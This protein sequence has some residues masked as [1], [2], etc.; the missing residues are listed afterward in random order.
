MRKIIV[1]P[2]LFAAACAEVGCICPDN[3]LSRST[4]PDGTLVATLFQ[5]DCGATTD[6]STIVSVQSPSQGFRDERTFVFVAKGQKSVTV[7]WTSKRDLS[8]ECEACSRPTVFKE[9]TA[10]GDINI[11]YLLPSVDKVRGSLEGVSVNNNS[12]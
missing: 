12:S 9:V 6:Y 1:V 3:V 7:K 10:L 2:I 8:I 5:R 4:S 11:V